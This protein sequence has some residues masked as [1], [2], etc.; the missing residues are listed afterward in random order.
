MFSVRRFPLKFLIIFDHFHFP[1]K[2]VF[3]LEK[4]FICNVHFFLANY[5]YNQGGSK[6]ITSSFGTNRYFDDCL[7]FSGRTV[8]HGLH[9]V[10]PKVEMC[11]MCKCENGQPKVISQL[12]P[13]LLMTTFLLELPTHNLRA[14]L[15]LSHV[16]DGLVVLRIH[17]LGR[18]RG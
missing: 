2:K 14:A 18:R 12:E 17:L 3:S 5:E 1:P 16:Y 4:F 10:P 11:K 9:F 15:R 8:K 7:D 6:I 13:R